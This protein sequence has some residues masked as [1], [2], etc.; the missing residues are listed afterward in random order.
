MPQGKEGLRMNIINNSDQL[1]AVLKPVPLDVK[2]IVTLIDQD[3]DV[4]LYSRFSWRKWFKNI[5]RVGFQQYA[6]RDPDT[7]EILCKWNLGYYD[8]YAPKHF[9]KGSKFRMLELAVTTTDKFSVLSTFQDFKFPFQIR[10][11]LGGPKFEYLEV[12]EWQG[13][14]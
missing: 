6:L 12:G 4:R 7:G 2:V 5:F 13:Q 10:E 11:Q 3:V 8:V 9:P 14:G 1:A